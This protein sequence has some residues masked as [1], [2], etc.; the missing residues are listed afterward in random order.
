YTTLFRSSLDFMGNG[1]LAEPPHAA[2]ARQLLDRNYGQGTVHLV[3]AAH[4]PALW[5]LLLERAWMAWLPLALALAAFLWMRLQRVG[6]VLP[7]PDGERRSLLEHVQASG[8]HLR[9]YGRGALLHGALRE[10]FL[11][12]LRRRDP[13]AAA[14]E[15]AAR[16]EAIAARTGVAAAEIEYALCDPRP[17]DRRDFVQRIAR[18]IDLRRRL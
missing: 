11:D 16:A 12:R 7:R 9:R 8:E 18:L 1:K 15:G 2:L 17:R 6:P 5:R 10:A 4:M 13:M 3:Y 14:L